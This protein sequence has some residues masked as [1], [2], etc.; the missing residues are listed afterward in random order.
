MASS[1]AN[2]FFTP[3]PDP[4]VGM[5][6]SSTPC[7]WIETRR[8]SAGHRVFAGVIIATIAFLL[9]RLTL[10]PVDVGSGT[11]AHCDRLLSLQGILIW[12][13]TATK[14][15]GVGPDGVTVVRYWGSMWVCLVKS[16][17]RNS[18]PSGEW[19]RIVGMDPTRTT[20][21]ASGSTESRR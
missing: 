11:I 4:V 7:R 12:V 17:T 20:A 8:L 5:Q 3:C 15:I 1:S 19:V 6:E 21:E 2:L 18:D 10:L 14:R 13:V 9:A 16:A